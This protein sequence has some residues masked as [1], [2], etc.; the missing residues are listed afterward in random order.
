MHTT[1]ALLRKVVLIR[2]KNR[3]Q[4]ATLTIY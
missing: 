1:A 3:F 4:S 2:L